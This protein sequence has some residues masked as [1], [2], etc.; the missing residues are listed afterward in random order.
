M[1]WFAHLTIRNKMFVAV[2][3]VL[4]C[5]TAMGLFA[6]R[7]LGRLNADVSAVTTSWLPSVEDLGAIKANVTQRRV[8]QFNHVLETSDAVMEALEQQ[9]AIG[10]QRL[11]S[12]HTRYEAVIT[13]DAERG[14]YTRYRTALAASDSSW[15]KARALSRSQHP[16]DAKQEMIGAGQQ[17]FAT[18]SLILDSLIA[19]NHEGAI[20]AAADAQADYDQ[21][22]LAIPIAILLCIGLGGI[23]A[24]TAGRIVTTA[25][26]A[27][28]ERATSLRANCVAGLRAAITAMT[29]GDLSVTVTPVTRPIESKD[30]DEIGKISRVVD[31]M[32]AEAQQTIAAFTLTQD[33]LRSV[34]GEM[35]VVVD[36]ARAGRLTERANVTTFPGAYRE[37]VSGLNDTIAAAA[38][39]LTEAQAVLQR[40]A[41]RDLTRRMT[42]ECEGEYAAMRDAINVAIGNLETT[43]AQV[44][45]AATQVSSASSE[46]TSGSQS[47]ASGASEQAAALEEIGASVQQVAGVSRQTATNAREAE[48]LAVRARMHVTE[49][50]E[51]MQRLSGAVEEIRTGSEQTAKIVKTIEEIAFQTNLLALNAAV[52]AARAG[53]AG[54]GFAVVAEE[55][56]AL[57]LRSAAA[58]KTTAALIE[59]SVQSV[60]RGVELNTQVLASLEQ[61]NA[62]FERVTN[63]VTEIATSA[64]EQAQ[65]VGQINGAIAQL[66]GVTQQVASNSEESA[67]AAEELASQARML[68]DTVAT[69]ELRATSNAGGR[70]AERSAVGRGRPVPRIRYAPESRRSPAPAGEP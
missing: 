63:V 44:S 17:R 5:N 55:V 58:A 33:T 21:A 8:L 24:I 54:R 62:Q 22:R 70:Q 52:E 14:Q 26:A 40:V 67:S 12:A 61:I 39:P 36:A 66:N 6:L 2:G 57:A 27:V 64:E 45:D 18:T 4:S 53:D 32:I 47:L 28:L 69:F 30:R 56:R 59:S 51:M 9:L 46:I 60:E 38:A 19:L 25:A 68:A 48:G 34:L 42:G 1:R 13:S 37:L 49:G 16:D 11:D 35:Q 20:A 3:V 50:T 65:G 7:L 23:V 43:L 15:S 41:T 31:E 29:A 10:S